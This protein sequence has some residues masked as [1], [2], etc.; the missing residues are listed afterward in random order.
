MSFL[1]NN[2]TEK[3][4]IVMPILQMKKLRRCKFMEI[5]QVCTTRNWQSQDSNLELFDHKT[6]AY[7]HILYSS[8]MSV[9]INNSALI[10]ESVLS[11]FISIINIHIF[12][13]FA[14]WSNI[15]IFI[16][17]KQNMS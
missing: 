8:I 1:I 4:N 17:K 16:K 7:S 9:H 2:N 5:A 3:I 14:A 10:S 11:D 12:L 13:I 15:H 6:W